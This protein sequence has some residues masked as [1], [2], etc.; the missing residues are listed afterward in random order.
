MGN[1]LA[2]QYPRF[3]ESVATEG[4]PCSY[5]PVPPVGK[6]EAIHAPAAPPVLLTSMDG[7]PATPLAGAVALQ[8]QLRNGS[9]LVVVP[10]EMHTATEA[11]GPCLDAIVRNYMLR[12][13]LPKASRTDCPSA[14]S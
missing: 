8:Q 3:G 14:T 4:L 2:A 5:W 13:T 7:D 1:E 12:G 6:A 11:G 9:R 10:G